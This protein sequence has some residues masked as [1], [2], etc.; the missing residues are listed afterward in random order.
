MN[1]QKIKKSYVKKLENSFFIIIFLLFYSCSTMEVQKGEVSQEEIAK[2]ENTVNNDS[3]NTDAVKQLAILLVRAHQ[4]E[5]AKY[6]LTKALNNSP[7]DDALLFHQGLNFEFLNDTL[8]AIDYYSRYKETPI[9]S[10]YRKL[11]EGRYYLLSRALV[12]KD[13]KNL[14]IEENS[15][16]INSIPS[17]TIAVFPLNYHGSNTKYEPLSRGLSEMISI[18]LGKVKK[19]TVLERIRLKAIMDELK[20]SKSAAVD[21]STAPRMGKLLSARLLY[22][23]SFNILEDDNLKMDIN[24]WDIKKNKMGEWLN[25]SG[26]LEDIFLMEKELVFDIIN[27]LG[28]KLTQEEKEQI[29]F[30][31]T[32]DI[33]A[34][35][36]YSRG[37]ELEDNGKYDEAA[38]SFMK[39]SEMDPDFKEAT[40]KSDASSSINSSEGNKEEFLERTVEINVGMEKPPAGKEEI[41]LNRLDMLGGDIRSNFDQG[42]EKRK[43]PQEAAATTAIEELPLPPPPPKN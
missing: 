35:L 14:V 21:Q 34:F 23:G 7:E 31:P 1:N 15:L 13:I 20:F 3:L 42:F 28:I 8:N 16:N 36:E 12:Y 26:K 11:M 41:I 6:Y 39:A 27:Q 25:K 22:S 40:I 9:L 19:L 43:A 2:L 10:S 38:S 37:L 24:S 32:K 29:Q 4:H 33:N 30:I 5:K 17:N 18:D